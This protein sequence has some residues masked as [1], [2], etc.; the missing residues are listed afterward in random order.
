[1]LFRLVTLDLPEHR[2][3]TTFEM[4]FQ[5]LLALTDTKQFYNLRGEK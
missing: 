1:M 2:I 3:E 5:E 4:I